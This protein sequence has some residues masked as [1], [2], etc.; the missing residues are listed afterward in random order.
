LGKESEITEILPFEIML[1]APGQGSLG[2][3][4]RE[5]DT[6]TENVIQGLNHPDSQAAGT[7]ER[8]FQGSVG[9][10]CHVP[11][12][13][14]ARMTNGQIVLDALIAAPDGSA[15]VRDRIEGP[16]QD[17]GHLGNALGNRILAAGG[18]EILF[19]LIKERLPQA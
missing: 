13:A 12:A 10:N 14:Y 1:P 19:N 6:R 2:I 4:I 17:A 5:D 3:E 7:A 16:S 8:A 9:G 11:I 18:S 15:C